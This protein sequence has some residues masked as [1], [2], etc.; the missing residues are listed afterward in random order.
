[1]LSVREECR[2]LMCR[3]KEED[4]VILLMGAIEDDTLHL[5]GSGG[6]EQSIVWIM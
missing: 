5:G 2:W 4:L 6:E 3:W 1:M